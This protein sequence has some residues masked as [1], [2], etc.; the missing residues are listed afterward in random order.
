MGLS[1][2]IPS[3]RIKNLI[4]CVQAVRQ[5]EP[6]ARI[7]VMDDGIEWHQ[8]ANAF[9]ERPFDILVRCHKPFNY[10]RNCNA[11][12][13]LTDD[14]DVVLL[15]D[16]AL[17]QTPGGFSHL[18]Q[19]SRVRPQFGVISAVMQTVGNTNQYPHQLGFREEKLRLCFVCVFIPRT[20]IRIVGELDER[21]DCYSHQD[22]D[23]S[24]RV[25]RAGLRLGIDDNC[26]V[27]HE[28][29]VSTFRGP[30][31]NCDERPGRDIFKQKWGWVA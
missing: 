27:D 31:G 9:E 28:S 5:H 15:N 29:L 25:L 10:S 21:F 17:L 23:Y 2:I 30:G 1:V 6:E 14:D 24:W 4:P 7:V 12:M 8:H 19:V 11:G 13:R 20:T 16:D 22:D 3:K 18:Q 26:R